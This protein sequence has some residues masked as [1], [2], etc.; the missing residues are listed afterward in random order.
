[1]VSQHLAELRPSGLMEARKEGPHVVHSVSDGHLIRLGREIVNH[2]G[3]P[4][5]PHSSR[6]SMSGGRSVLIGPVRVLG[7]ACPIVEMFSAEGLLH[8]SIPYAMPHAFRGPASSGP[9]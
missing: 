9:Q 5:D 4:V 7:K 3:S 8:R 2:A 1:M 6:A